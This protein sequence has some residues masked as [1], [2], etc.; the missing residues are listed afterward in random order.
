MGDKYGAKNLF[1]KGQNVGSKAIS[2]EIGK[3]L[4]DEGIKHA[5]ELYKLGA[6]EIK[7][8]NLR[9]ALDSDIANYIAEQ[10]QEKAKE[11]LDNLFSGIQKTTEGIRNFQTEEAF[12]NI[13]DEDIDNNFMGI[14]P[15]NYINKFID[16]ASMISE[17]R[18]NIG[19]S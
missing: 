14:F 10:S 5:P 12:K 6:S 15:S 16:H 19:L 3:K 13:G 2:S 8:K 4:I 18:E 1:K 9:R 11:N 7:N 17:K